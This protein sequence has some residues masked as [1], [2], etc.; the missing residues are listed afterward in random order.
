MFVRKCD[1]CGVDNL[2]INDKN[3]L[4]FEIKF[5]NFTMAL[6]FCPK[7]WGEAGKDIL[8]ELGQDGENDEKSEK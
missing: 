5:N 7:C 3:F 4:T 2:T 6:D 1:R 8:K